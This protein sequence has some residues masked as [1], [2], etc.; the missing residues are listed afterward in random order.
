MTMIGL[1]LK[2]FHIPDATRITTEPTDVLYDP[3]EPASFTCAATTDSATTLTY[4]WLL[5]GQPVYTGGINTTTNTLILDLPS[6]PKNGWDYIG[7]WTCN[8]TNTHSWKAASA[9]LYTPEPSEKRI[10]F[11]NLFTMWALPS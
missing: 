1:I 5:N 10:L 9:R 7:T 2:F 4:S 3:K 11:S 6:L 8:A